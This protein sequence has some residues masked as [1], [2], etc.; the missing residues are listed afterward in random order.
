M[1]AVQVLGRAALLTVLT[2]LAGCGESSTTRGDAGTTRGDAGTTR[3]AARLQYLAT[4]MDPWEDPSLVVSLV[5]YLRASEPPADG[6]AR[7]QFDAMFAQQLLQAGRTEEAIQHFQ[8]VLDA[9]EQQGEQVSV[10]VTLAVRDLLAISYLRLA[11]E[12][13]CVPPHATTRCAVPMIEPAGHPPEAARAAVEQYRLLLEAEPQNHVAR[14]FLNLAHMVLGEYPDGVPAEWLIA[15]DALQSE[16]DILRFRDVAPDLGLDAL[17]QAGGSIMDD[18]NGDGYLDVMA[19][20]RGLSDQLRYFRNNGDGTFTE[21]SHE[22]GLAGLVGG[23]N[24]TQA[25]YNNDGGLDVLVLRGAWL[26]EGLPNSLLRN[27][28]DGTFED[29]TEDAGLLR[30]ELPTQTASWGDYNNDGWIDLYVGNES[31]DRARN[32]GQL[33]R[34]NRDGTFTDVARAAGADVVGFIKA[35]VWGDVDNDGRL[36]LYVSRFGGP[37]VL[38]RNNG[39]DSS[40]RWTFTDISEAADI[41]EPS[42]SFSMWFWD[43]DNDGWQ[44]IFVTGRRGTS[45]DVAAEYLGLPHQAELS[46]LYRNNGDGTF[47]DVTAAVGLDKIMLAMGANFGDLDSDGYLDFYVGTGDRDFRALV[48]NRMFRNAGGKF[49]QDVTTSGGFGQLQKGHGVA[50]GDVDNDG[51]QDIYIGLGGAWGGDRSYN[52][53]F[54]NPGHGNRWI[55]L[56]LEGVRSNRAAIGARI[57]ITV[58]TDQ[59][60]R[61]I[62]STVTSGGSFGANSLQQE[63]GLGQARVIRAL[64]VTWPATGDTNVYTNVPMN[65]IYALR[66]GDSILTP[67][68]LRRL[69]FPNRR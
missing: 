45:G 64:T 11:H 37:N 65:Q 3:M 63:I 2:L 6:Y 16:Y 61:D 18:F 62:Y 53:L 36:D 15:A 59:G 38:L 44:D 46:L 67:V 41:A 57:K 69:S 20:S 9:I 12:T 19:S 49:F 1:G 28:G 50:F 48:P 56:K 29:V 35:A 66:E 8:Q 5:A 32:P 40:G 60:L 33:F 54:E 43:Y 23:L 52:A 27:N 30:P 25:D 68:V 39:P 14:W 10:S 17:G 7:L 51:D 24:L 58:E 42:E 47:S 22:A 21:R 31:S 26:Q 13:I 4:S 34:N 55:T